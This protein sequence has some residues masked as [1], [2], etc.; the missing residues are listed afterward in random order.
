MKEQSHWGYHLIVDAAKC[1]ENILT[2]QGLHSFLEDLTE[3]IDMIAYG[4]PI[5]KHFAE[6]LPEAAGFSIVQLIETSAIT[7]HFSDKNKDAYLDIFS[8]KW[9]SKEKA[10]TTIYKHFQ[11]KTMN[12]LWLPREAK[13][14]ANNPFTSVTMGQMKGHCNGCAACCCSDAYI[15]RDENISNWFEIHGYDYPIGCEQPANILVKKLDRDSV[16]IIFF[17]KCKHLVQHDNG[18]SGCDMYSTRPKKCRDFPSSPEQCKVI[19]QC[20]FNKEGR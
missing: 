7:G 17:D 16:K 14:P 12:V 9:F 5:I 19:L 20:S 11:P 15:L 2:E 13:R 8:C 3:T 1:N 6:H 4:E 10:L 18:T